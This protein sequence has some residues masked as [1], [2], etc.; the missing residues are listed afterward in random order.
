MEKSTVTR[1][2]WNIKSIIDLKN[3]PP[4]KTVSLDWHANK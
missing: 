4:L 2:G 1:D 3:P